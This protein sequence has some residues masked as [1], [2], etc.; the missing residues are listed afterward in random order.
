MRMIYPVPGSGTI[1]RIFAM[2]CLMLLVAACSGSA[3]SES[4]AVLEVD[5]GS[6]RTVVLGDSLDLDAVVT[7]NGRPS[8]NDLIYSWSKVSGPGTASFTEPDAK[9]TSVTFAVAGSYLLNLHVEADGSE[10]DDTLE[11]TVNLP[12]TLGIDTGPARTVVLGDP[13]ALDALITENG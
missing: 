5:T 7:E 4:R 12:P 6:A 13:I 1:G 11:V 9:A 8:Q 10:A 2:F 3:G